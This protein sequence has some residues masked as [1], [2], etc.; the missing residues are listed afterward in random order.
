MN[1]K[2]KKEILEL[3]NDLYDEDFP[4]VNESDLS[5]YDYANIVSSSDTDL[6]NKQ[7]LLSELLNDANLQSDE[8]EQNTVNIIK[9]ACLWLDKVISLF[10]NPAVGFVTTARL[11]G[12]IG[13]DLLYRMAGSFPTLNGDTALNAIKAADLDGIANIDNVGTDYWDGDPIYWEVR[14][15]D[16]SNETDTNKFPK[17]IY[18]YLV[19]LDGAVIDCLDATNNERYFSFGENFFD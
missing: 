12:I 10:H 17:P 1:E 9:G 18:T 14:L 15:Y 4:L 7:R 5:L 11:M 3:K 13:D 16:L 2:L 19:T 8:K 6:D